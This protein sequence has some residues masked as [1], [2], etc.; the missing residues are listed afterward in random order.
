[1]KYFTPELLARCRSTDDEVADDAADKWEQ[2][3]AAYKTRLRKIR[4][5]L[6]LGVRQLLRRASLH[7]AQC[8]VITT[9]GSG[10]EKELFLTFRLAGSSQQPAGGVELRYRLSGRTTLLREKNQEP[11]TG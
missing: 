9:S 7:D 1:M 4:S 8:L 2:A 6:P 5:H 10:A 3:L 11:A